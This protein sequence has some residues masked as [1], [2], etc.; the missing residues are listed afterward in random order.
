MNALFNLLDLLSEHIRSTWDNKHT[1]L[2]SRHAVGTQVGHD[3]VLEH[4]G[5][6]LH[7]PRAILVVAPRVEAG[8]HRISD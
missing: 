5:E 7:E 3:E 1:G 6:R 8:H 2:S 4:L